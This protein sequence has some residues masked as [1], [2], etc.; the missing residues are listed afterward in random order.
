MVYIKYYSVKALLCRWENAKCWQHLLRK[1]KGNKG[2]KSAF[3]DKTPLS[4]HWPEKSSSV[5]IA[6]V[7]LHCYFPPPCYLAALMIWRCC[8][9]APLEPDPPLCLAMSSLTHVLL[10]CVPPSAFGGCPSPPW[11]KNKTKHC[12]YSGILWEMLTTSF[13]QTTRLTWAAVDSCAG[14]WGA[15]C[16]QK[17]MVSVT[18]PTRRQ[19]LGSLGSLLALLGWMGSP[20]SSA[21]CAAAPTKPSLQQC[22]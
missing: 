19:A 21:P 12:M 9:E 7:L 13:G 22:I 18:H 16:S 14:C 11:E 8:L 4:L 20:H 1:E 10:L 5:I 6:A 15:P 2:L 17:L 3:V